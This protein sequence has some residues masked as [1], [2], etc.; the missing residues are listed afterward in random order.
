MMATLQRTRR[1]REVPTAVVAGRTGLADSAAAEA[2]GVLLQDRSALGVAGAHPQSALRTNALVAIECLL[3]VAQPLAIGLAIN[4]LLDASVRGLLVFA[5]Q[6]L[7]LM[8]A[9][10]VRTMAATRAGASLQADLRVEST[11]SSGSGGT[12]RYSTAPVGLTGSS[13]N[14]L[15]RSVVVGGSLLLL[16][17][18]DLTL[19]PFCL[20]LIVPVALLRTAGELASPTMSVRRGRQQEVTCE[21]SAAHGNHLRP[22]RETHLRSGV[23]QGDAAAIR[24]ALIDLF[25]LGMLASALVHYLGCGESAPPPGD[26][27]AVV[28]ALLLFAK[29]LKGGPVRAWP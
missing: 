21:H 6:H 29:G 12:D 20:L 3:R 25:V 16:A 1:E 9:T 24:G 2:P 4:D 8:S 14:Q 17:W 11:C 19:L 10:A 22:S 28:S 5:V 23:P 27:F 18:Y 15:E 26:I 7:L 13:Q